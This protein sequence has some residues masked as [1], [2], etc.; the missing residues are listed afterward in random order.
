MEKIKEMINWE[1]NNNHQQAVQIIHD[2][3]YPKKLKP[4]FK[5]KYFKAKNIEDK[6]K[7]IEHPTS[8]ALTKNYA[9]IG[10]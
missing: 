9:L 10:M 8:L 2:P 4:Y 7:N 3:P 5:A 1:Y 6:N